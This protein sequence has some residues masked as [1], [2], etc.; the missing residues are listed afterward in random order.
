MAAQPRV[1]VWYRRID[2]DALIDALPHQ[3]F[4]QHLQHVA[5]DARHRDSR[6]AVRQLCDIGVDGQ[7]QIRH[8]PPLIWR[9]AE[10]DGELGIDEPLERRVEHAYAG[11][12]ESIRPEMRRFLSGYNLVDTASKAVGVGSVGTRCSIGLLV[13]PNADDVL[14]M[15]SK[16]AEASVFAAYATSASA[17]H[18]GQRVVEGQ[19]LMQTV[20][21]P[22]LG[23][24]TNAHHEHLYWRHFRDWKG[25]V[26]LEKLDA[27]GLDR[28]GRLCAM[29]LA[30]AHARSGDRCALAAFMDQGKSFDQAIAA[31]SLAY[32]DQSQRDYRRFL[33]AIGSGN[34]R[35]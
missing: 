28:Y 13:G 3:A 31:Y 6:Q 4:R 1:D 16:Q 9:H 23:W 20:S 32:A 34:L 2:V 14:V 18:Q 26:Q 21:D 35:A 10:M 27:S 30:K 7:L 25:S 5:A 22:L 15:Q 12:L 8:A 33:D 17:P 24:T 19:R 11:Y 29:T